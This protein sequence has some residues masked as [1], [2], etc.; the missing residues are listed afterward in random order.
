MSSSLIR[1]AIV[2]ACCSVLFA[3]T[4]L[5]PPEPIEAVRIHLGGDVVWTYYA[6]GPV[7]VQLKSS[8]RTA[9]PKNRTGRGT[10]QF[11][12]VHVPGLDHPVHLRLNTG[13][14]YESSE[15]MTIFRTFLSD[16]YE[17]EIRA[18]E[19]QNARDAVQIYVIAL[20]PSRGHHA[21][22]SEAKNEVMQQWLK[23]HCKVH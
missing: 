1:A 10:L 18:C 4:V 23:A 5:N 11:R 20:G 19:H 3:G 9:Y 2:G 21:I 14:K 17:Q 13:I 7:G 15:G 12:R 16:A 6:Y 8:L 22:D